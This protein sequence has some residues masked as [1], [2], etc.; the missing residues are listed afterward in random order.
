[1]KKI[2]LILIA[3]TF[4]V[5]AQNTL[6][7]KEIK[8]GWKLLFDGKTTNGWRN[9]KSNTINPQWKVQAG[10]I[11]L[12]TVN[13]GDIMT[14]KQYESFE[15]SLEWKIADCGNSGIFYHVVEDSAYWATY[16]TGPEMQILDDKCHP[17]NKLENHRAGSL[18]DMITPSKVTVKKAGEWN[19]V[20]LI[21]NQNKVKHYLN[22]VLIVEYTLFSPEWDAMVAKSKFADWKGFGK[23]KK[24]HI[25]LQDHGDT[26]SFRNIKIREL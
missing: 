18:Y 16:S 21:I 9:Y 2:T 10:A 5:F 3:L 8:Q 15:L 11:V 24:G 1:M 20:L 25:A 17:D 6:T 7:K 12:T 19:K 22:D 23:F 26:V 4:S 14:E 13:G